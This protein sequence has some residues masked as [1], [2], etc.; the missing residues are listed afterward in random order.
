MNSGY[1]PIFRALLDAAA[2]AGLSLAGQGLLVQLHLRANPRTAIYHTT[3]RR[4]AEET[5]PSVAA[6][7]EH[8]RRQMQYLREL[9][10]VVYPTDR[11]KHTY[12]V[13]LPSFILQGNPLRIT[14]PWPQT[15]MIAANTPGFRT[16]RKNAGQSPGQSHEFSTQLDFPIVEN[17]IVAY[18][19]HAQ[20]DWTF[21]HRD[22]FSVKIEHDP[23]G[24]FHSFIQLSRFNLG[25]A[26]QSPGQSPGQ[27]APQESTQANLGF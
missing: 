14:R 20:N 9:G 4:L 25:N 10:L 18:L 6:S 12:P 1:Q 17:Y 23:K 7:I 3:A 21:Q 19:Q 22:V 11:T 27:S 15:L 2:R 24:K 26:G 16:A 5:A 8:V 13:Y